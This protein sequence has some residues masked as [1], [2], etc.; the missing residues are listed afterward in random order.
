MTTFFLIEKLHHYDFDSSIKPELHETSDYPVASAELKTNDI[1]LQ[2]NSINAKLS[3]D[4]CLEEF[5]IVITESCAPELG[6]NSNET[7]PTRIKN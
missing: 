7:F 4:N 3:I 6:S 2:T 5:H 1:S